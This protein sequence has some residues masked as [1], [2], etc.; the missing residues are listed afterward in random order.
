MKVI[1]AYWYVFVAVGRLWLALA[2]T[3]V[4]AA[5]TAET[6]TTTRDAEA[7]YHEKLAPFTVG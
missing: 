4:E 2:A 1:R 3:P 6:T 7:E 5:T